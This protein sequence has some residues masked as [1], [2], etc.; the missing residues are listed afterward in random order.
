ASLLRGWVEQEILHNFDL[1]QLVAGASVDA[2][3]LPI[4]L[5]TNIAELQAILIKMGY[6]PDAQDSWELLGFARL[7]GPT[8]TDVVILVELPQVLKERRRFRP[9]RLPMFKELGKEALAAIKDVL[10]T[11][12]V[13]TYAQWSDVLRA[14]DPAARSPADTRALASKAEKGNETLWG[15]Q[16]GKSAVPWAPTDNNSLSR[17][18][19]AFLRR[20]DLA[21]RPDNFIFISI[22][23]ATSG[24][25]SVSNGLPTMLINIAPLFQLPEVKVVR[26]DL[27]VDG[28]P[29]F[30]SLCSLPLLS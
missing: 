27:L 3:S 2:Q 18:L 11:P 9:D 6:N 21:S 30:L 24:L 29:Q 14:G 25:N 28:F 20:S 22:I 10:R 12:H 7:E 4:R 16:S 5:P 1:I 15:D 19:A 17:L 8:P 26:C 13:E 23:P